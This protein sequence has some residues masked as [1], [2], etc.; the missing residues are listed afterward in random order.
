MEQ[1]SANSTNHER[2]R[3]SVSQLLQEVMQLVEGEYRFVQVVG[4]LSSF[5]QWRSGHWYFDLKDEQATLPSVMFKGLTSRVRFEVKD[6]M[7]VC[8]TGKLSIYAGQSRVQLIASEIEP[9]GQGALAL[10]FEQLKEKLEAEGLFA[11]ERKKKLPPFPLCVGLVTSPQGAALQDML[12]IFRQRMPKV[13]ILLAGARV[14]GEGSAQEIADALKKLDESGRCDVIIVGRGGGSLEDLWAFNEEVLARQIAQCKTPVVSAVGHETDFCIADFVAD[15][16]AATP[17]HAAGEVVP[18]L[19]DIEEWLLM[20]K[21]QLNNQM[22]ASHN[23]VRL[24][25][26]KLAGRLPEPRLILARKSQQLEMLANKIF[27][28]LSPDKKI[29][30][31]AS[32]LE[33]FRV[34][35]QQGMLKKESDSKKNLGL[36][37][38]KLDALSPLKTL[39][40][41]YAT[42]KVSGKILQTVFGL[43]V[44]DEVQVRISDG[45]IAAQ[46]T[47]INN[48][49]QG[50]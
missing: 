47:A 11:A 26:E 24:S 43:K 4:E 7:Q 45:E 48:F 8:I 21:R 35:L 13:N 49:S 12:R 31:A 3:H 22:Q 9:L 36:L 27:T 32:V 40:R 30:R 34:R 1:F 10:A 41:G 16:R 6:G 46:I 14:Q 23:R 19:A 38:A 15:K 17:T 28:A 37:S 39:S 33:N 25:V 18:S 5:K 42:A 44:G 2:K 29:L 50:K 20:K